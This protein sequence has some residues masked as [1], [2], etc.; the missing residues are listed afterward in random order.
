[1][2]K[3]QP[4]DHD[5]L[6]PLWLGLAW[7]LWPWWTVISTNSTGYLHLRGRKNG[8]SDPL[9]YFL[10]NSINIF[11]VIPHLYFCDVV[12]NHIILY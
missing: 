11:E 12:A 3:E 8:Q 7:E 4:Q 2:N 9:I 5:E 1:M 10:K 6:W